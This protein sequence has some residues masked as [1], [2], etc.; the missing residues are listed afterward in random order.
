MAVHYIG[1]LEPIF[2][3]KWASVAPTAA[4]AV[5][6]ASANRGRRW[7]AITCPAVT[8]WPA[9]LLLCNGMPNLVTQNY[10]AIQIEKGGSVVFSLTGDMP[11]AG[12]IYAIGI[13]GT[14]GLIAAEATDYPKDAD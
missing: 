7:I 10:A 5:Q 9:Q 13:G 11:W 4:A 1:G 3:V 12:A 8:S 2:D 14:S 6:V